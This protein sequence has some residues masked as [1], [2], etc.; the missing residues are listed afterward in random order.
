MNFF[1]YFPTIPYAFN[2]DDSMF[3][4]TLT[5]MSVHFIIKQQIK[6]NIT[7]FYNYIIQD[8]ERPDSLSVKLYGSVAY[9]WVIL[10]VNNIFTLFDW[11]LT[12]S[13]FNNYIIEKYGSVAAADAQTV[14]LTVGGSQVDATT[15]GLLTSQQ[16][17]GTTTM[18][19]LELSQNDA[20][21]NILIVPAAFIGPLA[22]D[23]Q[24]A[25]S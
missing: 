2:V 7:V 6:Q 15:Y 13:E 20:K 25:F 12:A 16:Q 10:L 18:Y 21:R 1:K 8:G 22:T 24:A 9:T 17:G 3:T 5:N 11:P 4:L 14:Y 23:L 19:E